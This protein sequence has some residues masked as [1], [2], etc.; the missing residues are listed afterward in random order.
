MECDEQLPSREAEAF[1]ALR[2]SPLVKEVGLID[3]GGRQGVYARLWCARECHP[4]RYSEQLKTTKARTSLAECAEELLDLVN[5]KH[6]D[7]LE[8]AERERSKCE[9]EA[10]AAAGPS[11]PSNAWEAMHAA[12]RVQPAADLAV[13]AERAA[14]EAHRA[15]KA[16]AQQL[17]AAAK[18]A[19]A[20]RQEADRLQEPRVA[21]SGHPHGP[22]SL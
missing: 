2:A 3:A 17:E 4:Q 1:A 18:A 9:A 5:Q 16:A 11:A 12:Q 19:E 6:G 7:H 22:W 13:D 10:A 21:H 8:A 14:A 15:E 20:A